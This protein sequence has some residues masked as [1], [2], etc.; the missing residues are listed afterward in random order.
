MR[1]LHITHHRGCEIDFNFVCK[2]IGHEVTVQN[3]D[4]NYNMGREL[5]DKLWIKHRNFYESF[6]VI[7][8]SDTAPLSRIF[9]R[10]AFVGKLI[11]WVCNRFDYADQSSNNCGF[12]DPTY[13]D[14]FRKMIV[15]PNTKVFS[16]TPFEHAYAKKYRGVDWGTETIKPC[17]TVMKL[18][19][20][21]AFPNGM[22]K[23]D[24]FLVTRYH[25][26]NIFMKL[27]DRCS[28][29]GIQNYGG[30]YA[31]PQELNG[32]RGIIHIPYAWSN[33]ALFENLNLG[34]IYFIP[35][36]EFLLKLS[37]QGNFFWSPPFDTSLLHLAE[38]YQPEHANIFAYF[39]NWDHLCTMVND[40]TMINEKKKSVVDF[41]KQHQLKTLNKW[42]EAI[43]KWN[44]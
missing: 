26:D 14:D 43:T 1:V 16:Y 32:I 20:Q 30:E 7:V 44:M 15:L 38:W 25:N 17:A 4:W 6:D 35:S 9:M 27:S 40:A 19:G 21:D 18:N 39:N 41:S 11:I 5:A 13:Y 12:P 8:T 24:A 29:L 10:D 37:S 31:G 33:L 2:A 3:A 34:N 36:K 23:K 22:L 28:S 42:Q